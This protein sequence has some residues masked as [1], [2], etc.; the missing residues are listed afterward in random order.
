MKNKGH[1]IILAAALI[2]LLT[3]SASA[4]SNVTTSDTIQL[5]VRVAQKTM[6]DIQPDNL[7]WDGV[8]PGTETNASQ[9]WG[10]PSKKP[11]VQIENIGSTNISR[12][13]FNAT[14]PASNPFGTG[15]SNAY[16]AG[17]FVVVKSNSSAAAPYFFPNL[18]EYNESEMIYLQLPTLN[19]PWA[20]G[21]FR[22]A[23]K[24][25]F[26]AINVS[27]GNCSKKPMFRIGKN[28]HNASLL[29]SVDLRDAAC[30][31]NLNGTAAGSTCRRGTLTRTNRAPYTGNNM[32][33]YADV[34]I[35]TNAAYENYTVAVYWN[36]TSKVKIMFY[37]WN[38]DAPGAQ[39]S[40]KHPAYFSATTLK[41]G[42][43]I[44]GNVKLRI[45][46]GTAYGNITGSLTATVMAINV[47]G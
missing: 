19:G 12:I 21:R 38:M 42:D 46:Y 7:G 15:R 41:P 1:R 17:N 22:A 4:Q 16:N 9:L 47:L 13:W 45:P 30:E 14:Y 5:W 6:V 34:A 10:W 26:W 35:G 2:L 29:G 18:I 11:A 37:K 25:Y 44:I 28:P 31:L 24:E 20:H 23:N 33:S 27:G 3:L 32:W 39:E 43:H 8:Q 36:C 40:A